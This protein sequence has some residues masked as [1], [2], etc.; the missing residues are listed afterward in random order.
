MKL[1]IRIDPFTAGMFKLEGLHLGN[2]AE[3]APRLR[4]STTL[5]MTGFILWS[6]P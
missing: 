3:A 5:E 2:F 4:G 6:D 1:P